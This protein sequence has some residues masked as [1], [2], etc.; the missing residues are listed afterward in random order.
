MWGQIIGS[1]I[2]AGLNYLSA[3][4]NRAAQ[5][6]MFQQN[7]DMQRE[8]AQHGIR[9][10]VEDAK[11]A[12]IHPLYA[13]GSSTHSYSPQFLG[14]STPANDY[15]AIGQNL[16]RAID[17][18]RT[19]NERTN[20]RLRE[21]SVQ[22]ASL[23][24]DLLKVQI[25]NEQT[26]LPPP[27][28]DLEDQRFYKDTIKSVPG[29]PGTEVQVYDLPKNKYDSKGNRLLYTAGGVIKF[30]RDWSKHSDVEDHLGDIASEVTGAA[31]TGKL[32]YDWLKN[33]LKD[34]FH[35]KVYKK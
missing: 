14:G 34:L 18:T 29:R 2:G 20:E 7:I 1:T 5:Q 10:K 21:L 33:K 13:L 12:G 22:R 19:R 24:N 4:K 15:A 11:A 31:N 35:F 23:E 9:W 3:K 16:G 30:P 26:Q 8:F 25:R 17:A 32:T 27:M 28:P 6:Q